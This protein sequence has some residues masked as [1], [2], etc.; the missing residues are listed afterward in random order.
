M[1]SV[2]RAISVL[3]VAGALCSSAL[4]QQAPADATLT[5]SGS[6]ISAGLGYTWGDG[7]L[8]LK[9]R[10]YAFSVSGL[11]VI[12]ARSADIQGT[13]EVFHLARLADFSGRY[14]PAHPD[15][16]FPEGGTLAEIK[17]QNGVVIRF[18]EATTAA[19]L[20]PSPSGVS[21]ILK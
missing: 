8:T 10:I 6:S 17:N 19:A 14:F 16:P 2:R 18:R 4:A 7:K 13:G 11:G 3:T 21:L 9:G 20:V 15:E 5:F 12:D 1:I